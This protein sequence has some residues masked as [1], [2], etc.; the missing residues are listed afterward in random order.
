MT[1]RDYFH[2]K[3]VPRLIEERIAFAQSP[4][5]ARQRRGG[6]RAIARGLHQLANRID[7]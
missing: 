7:N 3:V 1:E 5:P 4:R 6:R 2:D